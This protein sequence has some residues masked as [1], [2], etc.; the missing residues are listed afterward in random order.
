[1][2]QFTIFFEPVVFL[3]LDKIPLQKS[4]KGLLVLL[5]DHK[6]LPSSQCDSVVLEFKSFY[7]NN[8]IMLRTVFGDFNEATDH[9]DNFWFGKAKISH[10]KI[11]AFAVKLVLK[12]H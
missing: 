6:I 5:M 11:F 10:F 7:D 9:L 12:V 2:V 8:F 1:M 3:S 4:L